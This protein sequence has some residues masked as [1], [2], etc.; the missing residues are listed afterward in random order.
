MCSSFVQI[1]ETL[2]KWWSR[3]WIFCVSWI[4]F[5]ITFCQESL[6]F[7]PHCERWNFCFLADKKFGGEKNSKGFHLLPPYLRI[8]QVRIRNIFL[9]QSVIF[10]HFL[11]HS[12]PTNV[13]REIW[14][15][16]DATS[17]NSIVVVRTMIDTVLWDTL[18][19]WGS[20]ICEGYWKHARY[21]E[22]N[23]LSLF[24]VSIPSCVIL[25]ILSSIESLQRYSSMWSMWLYSA[26]RR[27]KNEFTNSCNFLQLFRVMESA[28]KP[29]L[30]FWKTWRSTNGALITSHLEAEVR[31]RL[32]CEMY[33]LVGDQAWGPH[34]R[35]RNKFLLRGYTSRR[36]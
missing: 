9:I 8:I 12:S 15:V 7:F 25:L 26:S 36:P 4:F 11:L 24:Q 23:A 31:T 17:K 10:L 30:K 33:K 1:Q 20:D 6:F 32:L 19:V 28:M 3:Y 16:S 29:C 22:V 34:C 14:L 5:Y 21:L 18:S 2:Q 35:L 27:R 13:F